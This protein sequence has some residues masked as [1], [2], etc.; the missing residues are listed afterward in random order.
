MAHEGADPEIGL[1]GQLDLAELVRV[2]ARVPPRGLGRLAGVVAALAHGVHAGGG[3]LDDVRRQ[4]GL[5]GEEEAVGAV[6]TLDGDDTGIGHSCENR[7]CSDLYHH[8]P[9]DPRLGRISRLVHR[10]LP[11]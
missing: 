7:A 1:L 10:R 5:G 3:G 2:V 4:N 9:G 8:L 11:P 6:S